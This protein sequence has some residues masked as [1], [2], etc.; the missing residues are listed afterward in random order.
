MNIKSL[1]LAATLSAISTAGSAAVLTETYTGV[2]TGLDS[3][4]YFDVIGG[5]L[6]AVP[7][8]ATFQVNTDAGING[9]NTG[10]FDRY[11]GTA[12]SATSPVT[13]ATLTI[14]GH[15]FTFSDPAIASEMLVENNANPANTFGA[16]DF[17]SGN[18]G[19]F[20][21][22]IFSHS[23]SA[24]NP[25][26]IDSPFNYSFNT[27]DNTFGVFNFGGDNIDLSVSTV[28]S[29]ASAVPEPSTWAMMILGFLGLGFM[30]YRRKQN[31]PALRVA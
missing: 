14:A 24:P 1:L 3:A 31:G 19:S 10:I 5:G 6:A 11:G 20:V 30:A 18:T 23:G 2:A 27:G 25:A 17:T 12:Y 21:L 4:G 22:Y 29:V 16:Y 26:T 13:T 15:S 9:D 7:F 8:T 28:A